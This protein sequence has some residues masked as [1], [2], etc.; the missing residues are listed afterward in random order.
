VR[1]MFDVPDNPDGLN[2]PRQNPAYLAA[3]PEPFR[4]DLR[5]AMHT[6]Q[7]LVSVNHSVVPTAVASD[8]VVLVGDAA[9]CCHPLTASGLTVS[10]RDAIRLRSA[11]RASGGD[12]R[13]A[14]RIYATGRGGPERTREALAEALYHAFMAQT[15]E[16]RLL[17][18]GLLRFWKHSRRGRAAS[19]ALLSTHEGRM[20]RMA[21]SYAHVMGYALITLV[22]RRQAGE[23]RMS[24]RPRAVLALGRATAR[25]VYASIAHATLRRA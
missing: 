11:L 9:G 3:L 20:S 14:R 6:Q 7:P 12:L 21:L 10:T 13:A 5:T 8:R 24:V 4:S 18:N 16:M 25:H 22:Q 19:M 1:V 23:A 15:P 2:A 17:R